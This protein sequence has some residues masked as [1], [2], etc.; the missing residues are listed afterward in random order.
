M[1]DCLPLRA[2]LASYF[3]I[4][5]LNCPICH[6]NIENSL[7]LFVFCDLAKKMW[8]TSPWN[9]RLDSLELASPMHFLR[10]LWDV[11]AQDSRMAT[12]YTARNIMLFAYVLCDL[13][14]K[15]RNDIT[16]GGTPMDPTLLF[17][18]INRSYTSILKNPTPPPPAAYHTWSPPPFGWVKINMDA[19]IGTSAATISCV[20]RDS[21]GDIISWACK[22]IP[23]C[24]PLVAEAC[25]ADFV[26]DF[27]SSSHWSAVNFSGDAKVV[28]DALSSLKSN[29]FWSF[30]SILENCILKL[31]SLSFWSFS[32]APREANILAHNLAQ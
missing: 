11:E 17:R 19:T 25:A 24:S 10:F 28:M 20:A 16:H 6:S 21:K 30:S 18:N 31:N 14:W 23:A 27:A 29:V 2:R 5:D 9:L 12:G 8:F 15:Y 13:L 3:P 4:P 26:I 1:T 22:A 7:H 32:F